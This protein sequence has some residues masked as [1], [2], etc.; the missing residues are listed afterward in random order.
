MYARLDA[1]R[2]EIIIKFPLEMKGLKN[3]YLDELSAI[4]NLRGANTTICCSSSLAR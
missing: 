4:A 2:R 1:M 3:L